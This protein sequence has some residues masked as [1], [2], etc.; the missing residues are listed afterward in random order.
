MTPVSVRETYAPAEAAPAPTTAGSMAGIVAMLVAMAA[1]VTN[2]VFVKLASALP[3][4]EIILLRNLTAAVLIVA[5]LAASSSKRQAPIVPPRIPFAMLGLRFVGEMV[6]TI[7]FLLALV[8]LPFAEVTAITQ[9]GPLALTAAAAV[10]LKEQVGWRRWMA[11]LV[12]F[13][14]VALIVRPGSAAFSAAGGMVLLSVV[15]VVVR[16]IATRQIG[17]EVSSTFI[18]LTSSVSGIVAGLL[19]WPFETWRPP[20]GL[21]L[22]YVLASGTFLAVGFQM[23]V[24][25]LRTGDV[26]VVAPF[27]YS[28][29]LYAL[30]AGYAVWGERPDGL[31]L[32][33]TAMVCFAGIYTFHRERVR[34]RLI[35]TAANAVQA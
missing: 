19:L 23:I 6:S 16:D 7:L 10:L 13:L 33:G 25:A 5:L 18:S 15:F 11:T 26:S 12:G 2:D 17:T 8:S 9:L 34:R 24:V 31:S 20:T 14:G 4:G 30:I 27:R 32:A 35:A 28:V 1:F 22:G 21:E 29:I 3:V